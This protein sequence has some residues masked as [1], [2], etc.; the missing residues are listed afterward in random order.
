M[1]LLPCPFCGG[2]PHRVDFDGT[3]ETTPN[4]GGSLIECAR[5]LSSGPVHFDRKENLES[6]WNE[7]LTDGLQEALSGMVGLIELID[8]RDDLTEELR[9]AINH[10]HRLIEARAALSAASGR[11]PTNKEK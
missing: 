8:G 10:S 3:D 11:A 6:G 4:A 9:F 2:E 7:R 5:C 1:D